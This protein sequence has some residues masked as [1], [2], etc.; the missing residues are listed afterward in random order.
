MDVKL[1]LWFSGNYWYLLAENEDA[2]FVHAQPI[3]NLSTVERLKSRGVPVKV[4]REV[5]M[6]NALC[7]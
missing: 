4:M 1:F 7:P 2:R 5:V 6:P 3:S